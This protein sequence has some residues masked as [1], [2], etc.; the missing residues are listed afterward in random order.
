MLFMKSL[1]IVNMLGKSYIFESWVVM[2]MIL[3]YSSLWAIKKSRTF[4][5]IYAHVCGIGYLSSDGSLTTYYCDWD[6]HGR[7]EMDGEPVNLE[8]FRTP[9]WVVKTLLI[10]V[11]AYLEGIWGRLSFS[12][13]WMVQH[14]KNSILNLEG[15]FVIFGS[16]RMASGS[17]VKSPSQN[18]EQVGTT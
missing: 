1:V 5:G 18:W 15:P 6:P 11:I 3:T 2:V 4:H 14:T 8:K 12:S 10:A 13:K 17:G 7:P 9:E 16:Y